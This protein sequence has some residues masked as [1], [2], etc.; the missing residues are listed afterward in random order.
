MKVN[1]IKDFLGQELNIGDKV[2]A[3]SHKRTSSTLYLGEIEKLTDKMVVIK[4]VDSKHDW[5]YEET[6]RVSSYKVV[7]VETNTST[8][9]GRWENGVSICP[10][11]GMDKFSGLDADIWADWQPKFC[12]NCGAK[13]DVKG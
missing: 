6:M 2:V 5:R 10:I 7:K 11:C 3:L 12:P 9:H 8:V 1:I 4:T 13:M